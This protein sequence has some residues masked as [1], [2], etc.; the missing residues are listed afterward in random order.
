[1]YGYGIGHDC[2]WFCGKWHSYAEH[3]SELSH[4]RKAVSLGWSP[5]QLKGN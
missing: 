3:F 5:S 4:F 2:Y 1:M